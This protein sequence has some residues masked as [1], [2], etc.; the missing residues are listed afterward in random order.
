LLGDPVNGQFAF[1]ETTDKGTTWT[2]K[3]HLGLAAL[4]DEGAFAA[5]NSSLFLAQRSATAF[6]TGGPAGPRV[7]ISAGNTENE[8]FHAR[9]LPLRGGAPSAGGFSID[10]RDRCCWVVVGGDYTKPEGRTA[11]A[12]FTQD[13]GKTWHAAQTQPHGFRSSVA[14]DKSAKAWIAVGPNGT[15]ISTDDGKNWR[16]LHPNPALHQAADADLHW[17]AISLPFVVGPHGRIG[18][19]NPAAVSP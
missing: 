5:S 11:I 8:P 10:E 16:P 7:L 13:G 18:K 19:L 12:A 1:W 15:D 3:R 4:E 6:V 9:A 2:R 17:N 14:Y